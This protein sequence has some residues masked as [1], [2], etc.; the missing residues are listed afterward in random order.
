MV[1][2]SGVFHEEWG[3]QQGRSSC[4]KRSGRAIKHSG[5]NPAPH[6]PT[7]ERHKVCPLQQQRAVGIQQA[8]V[9]SPAVNKVLQGDK[10]VAGVGGVPPVLGGPASRER[11][12]GE[13]H[14]GWG[15]GIERQA[16]GS[17]A[18]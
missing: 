2:T 11:W 9:A 13:V 16:A 15:G 17:R 12:H 3:G 6:P 4:C 7:G 8:Q 5:T 10:V 1:V 18:V 14:N